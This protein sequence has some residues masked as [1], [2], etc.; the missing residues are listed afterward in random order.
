V[1]TKI[2]LSQGH[3]ALIDDEDVPLV[4]GKWSYRPHPTGPAYALRTVQLGQ[5]RT[6]T[7]LMHRV[8]LDAPKGMLVDHI[9]GD[10]LDN[11]RANLRFATRS[12]NQQNL[13]AP[14]RSRTGVRGVTI[15]PRRTKPYRARLHLNGKHISLGYYETLEEASKAARDGRRKHFTHAS[16]CRDG[17]QP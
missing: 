8:I 12:Q 11:R 3:Y 15:V 13:H 4:T 1:V 9:N 17:A 5:R 2:P 10:G 7:K 16:E 14:S 6:M